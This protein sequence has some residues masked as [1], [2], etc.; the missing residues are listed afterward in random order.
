MEKSVFCRV[1]KYD[2]LVLRLKVLMASC[3]ISHFPR[4]FTGRFHATLLLVSLLQG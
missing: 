2:V 4:S 1:A 3:Y